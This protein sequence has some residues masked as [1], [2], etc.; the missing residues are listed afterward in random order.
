MFVSPFYPSLGC[1]WKSVN[2]FAS[3]LICVFTC[4]YSSLGCDWKSL[5]ATACFPIS[6]DFFPDNHVLDQEFVESFYELFPDEEARG[7]QK[8]TLEGTFHELLSQRLCQVSHQQIGLLHD[9]NLKL[10]VH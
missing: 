3:I 8:Q 10:D 6:T 7:N 4:F 1:D 9:Q 5:T 2:F